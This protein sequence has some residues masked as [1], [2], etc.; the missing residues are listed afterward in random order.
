MVE[1][2][3]L[4]DW[5]GRQL[6]R[7]KHGSIPAHLEPLVVRLGIPAEQWLLLVTKFST[8]FHSAAGRPAALE[9]EATRRQKR[10]THGLAPA[11]QIFH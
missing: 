4:L 8:L 11:R 6:R 10:W 7:D 3:Q 5:T 9:A 1:Y 2:L